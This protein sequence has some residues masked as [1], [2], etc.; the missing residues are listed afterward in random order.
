M[1]RIN[2]I[3]DDHANPA[4]QALFDGIRQKAGMV[5]NLYRVMAAEPAVL[6]ANLAIN[7]ALSDGSFDAATREAIALTTAGANHCEYCASAHTAI[8]KGLK[9]DADEIDNRLRA[10][11]GDPKL[12][13]ILSFADAVIE[14]RGFVSD[15][16]FDEA[17]AAGLT[18]GEIM[19]TV[20]N[21]VANIFTNYVNHV[22]ETE[23]DFPVVRLAE[24]QAA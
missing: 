6:A 13:A 7:D 24:A 12:Q 3:N 10:R 8:S 22:A 21:V 17:R 2:Q 18:D 9:V 19:E 20:A 15:A 14:S 5:P 4:A 1:S 16:Q 23:I 11:S